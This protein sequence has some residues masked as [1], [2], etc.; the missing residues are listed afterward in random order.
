MSQSVTL[1]PIDSN[2]WAQTRQKAGEWEIHAIGRFPNINWNVEILDT[3]N[4]YFSVNTQQN[5]P[6]GCSSES[7]VMISTN[8][9]F[10][11]IAMRHNS[12]YH[13]LLN[14]QSWMRLPVG[15]VYSVTTFTA[16]AGLAVGGCV[17]GC[18]RKGRWLAVSPLRRGRDG[19]DPG[20]SECLMGHPSSRSQA[21]G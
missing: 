11:K 10:Q 8:S 14:A 4:G 7:G 15:V 2:F 5:F 17:P 16:G 13:P 21:L 6:P 20:I 3:A 19:I 12:E 18:V 1:F 9:W